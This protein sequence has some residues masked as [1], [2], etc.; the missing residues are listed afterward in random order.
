MLLQQLTSNYSKDVNMVEIDVKTMISEP[1]EGVEKAKLPLINGWT[2]RSG[3]R[4]SNHV[5]NL[6]Y[7]FLDYDSGFTIQSF[8]MKYY[9][10]EFYLYTSSSH[11]ESKHKF[12]VI[13]PLHN[14]VSLEDYKSK[15]MSKALSMFFKEC[16]PTAFYLDHFFY[17]PAKTESY[18]Y[19]INYGTKFDIESACKK[20]LMITKMMVLDKEERLDTFETYKRD[21][22]EDKSDEISREFYNILAL[23]DGSGRYHKLF[24]LIGKYK[25]HYPALLMDLIEFSDYKHKNQ[26]KTLLLKRCY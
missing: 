4:S 8:M 9:R 17:I 13:V 19:K 3:K 20:E 18:T 6:S 22:F 16:D 7:L 10:Y 23:G 1:V 5:E 25:N 12:R 26:M 14:S 2:N 21:K 15:K 24:G 11:S